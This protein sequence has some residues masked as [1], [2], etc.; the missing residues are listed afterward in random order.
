M[1]RLLIRHVTIYQYTESVTL[2]PHKLLLR[3]RDWI[4]LSTPRGTL[5]A[6]TGDHFGQSLWFMCAVRLEGKVGRRGHKS[7]SSNLSPDMVE[8]R[9]GKENKNHEC[10][11]PNNRRSQYDACYL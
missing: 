5:R 4:C 7:M 8:E 2:L 3:T 9:E 1:R 11:H 6:D 10:I